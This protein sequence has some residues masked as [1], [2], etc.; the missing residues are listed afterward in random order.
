MQISKRALGPGHRD[1]VVKDHNT[2]DQGGRAVDLYALALL[3]ATVSAER[4]LDGTGVRPKHPPQC[5]GAAVTHGS[6]STEGQDASH[7]SALEA[8]PGVADRVNTAVETMKLPSS[9]SP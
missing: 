3:P 2:G 6:A 8:E 1:V 9:R 7:A 5:R 4:Y